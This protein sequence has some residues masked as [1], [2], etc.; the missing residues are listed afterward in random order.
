MSNCKCKTCI[1]NCDDKLSSF[2]VF[3]IE[4]N[5]CSYERDDNKPLYGVDVAKELLFDCAMELY[6]KHKK[7][8][9][10]EVADKIMDIVKEMDNMN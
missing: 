9:N 6:Y 5:Y 1:H 8:T 10:T 4:H 3:C 7:L 2:E